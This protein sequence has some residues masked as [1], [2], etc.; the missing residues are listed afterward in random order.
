MNRTAATESMAP[1]DIRFMAKQISREIKNIR[2][3][4]SEAGIY[5]GKKFVYPR[6]SYKEKES[7]GERVR[8]RRII[9]IKGNFFR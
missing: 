8:R 1:A 5:E 2:R 9:W 7:R 6:F 4:T 3:E